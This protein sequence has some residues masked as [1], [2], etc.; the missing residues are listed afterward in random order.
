MAASHWHQNL[1][2]DVTRLDLDILNKKE[3]LLVTLL[4]QENDY[5][6]NTFKFVMLRNR[7]SLGQYSSLADSDHGVFFL[8]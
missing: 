7:R 5:C 2:T 4:F 3:R 8:C 1:L 6:Y